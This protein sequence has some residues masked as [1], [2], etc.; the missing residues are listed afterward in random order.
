[1]KRSEWQA[2]RK[3]V[4][5]AQQGRCAT[6]GCLAAGRDV[7][8]RGAGFCA[9]CRSCRLRFDGHDRAVK[10]RHTIVAKRVARTGQQEIFA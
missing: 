7:V 5:A 4:L 1:M 6:A 10:A 3:F 2:T 9:F 8:M